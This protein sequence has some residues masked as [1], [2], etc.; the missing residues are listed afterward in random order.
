MRKRP[1]MYI[2]RP[3]R[4]ACTTSSTRSSTTRSTR[5]SPATATPSTSRSS[6]TAA[7][8]SSTTAAASRSTS[9]RPRACR[10]VEVVLTV[11]HAGGKFGGGGYAVSGGLHGVGVS[12]VNALSSRLDVEVQP[13]GPRVAP[14][15]R[16]RRARRAPLEQGE[17]E[18]RDRH[19]DHVLA[20][21]RDLRD[22]RL[23]LRDAAR[24]ASSR[25]RSSTRACTITLT[26][27][28][29]REPTS[30]TRTAPRRRA[31]TFRYERRPRRLRRAPQ[32]LARRPRSC[33]PEVI[34][35]EAE[36]IERRLSRRGR[37]AVDDRATARA[38]TPTRTRSTRTR[39]APT[40]R[41]SARR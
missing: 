8:A 40:R 29:P 19:D 37:D 16:A 7:C 30:T 33:N 31:V 5:R 14:G 36:D 27:E 18:R 34:D 10:A 39:A 13:A 38:S 9:T 2:G 6:P 32:R 28:R 12:V 25:W 21:R 3:A 1:G 22:R 17:A 4:A 41:A 15:V 23:R 35:F 24:A 20:E 11:L 26:D